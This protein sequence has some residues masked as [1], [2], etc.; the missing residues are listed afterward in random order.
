MLLSD[1]LLGSFKTIK[2][3]IPDD[4]T[5]RAGFKYMNN[6]LLYIVLFLSI[7]ARGRVP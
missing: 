1:E 2:F 7:I 6:F 4:R 3:G 5:K